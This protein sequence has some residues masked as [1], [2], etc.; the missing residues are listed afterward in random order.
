[1]VVEIDMEPFATASARTLDGDRD[2]LS[3]DSLSP[4]ID[5]HDRVRDERMYTAVPGHVDEPDEVVLASRTDPTEAM[6]SHLAIPVGIERAVVKR[7]RV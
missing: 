2:E 4:C 6:P 7:L 3:P 5:R 1:M